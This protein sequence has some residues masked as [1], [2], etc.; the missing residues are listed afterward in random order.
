MFQNPELKL[1]KEFED[2][3][4]TDVDCTPLAIP[5]IYKKIKRTYQGSKVPCKSCNPAGDGNVE[6][7]LDCPYC[8]GLGYQWTEGIYKGWFYKQTYMTDRSISSSVPLEMGIA[9]FNKLFLV[10]DKGLE[11]KQDDII[12]QPKISKK[13]GI[14]Y[15]I[16]SQGIFKV[17]ESEHNAANQRYAEFNSVTLSSTFGKYFRGIIK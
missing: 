4:H 14:E 5:F 15:P 16:I 6:G 2:L 10:F 17:F 8:E 13:G 1:D 7:S 11:L 3:L 9:N 12:L